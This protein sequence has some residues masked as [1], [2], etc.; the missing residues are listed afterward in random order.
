LFAQYRAV[1]ALAGNDKVHP[2]D[3]WPAERRLHEPACEG[4]TPALAYGPKAR[5]LLDAGV[6]VLIKTGRPEGAAQLRAACL[7]L[8]AAQTERSA[9]GFWKIA[10]GFFDALARG[11]IKPDVYAKRTASRVLLH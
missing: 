1:Q 9:R 3:L 10:A 5:A 11:L 8:V 7:G 4:D 2:A 6:L